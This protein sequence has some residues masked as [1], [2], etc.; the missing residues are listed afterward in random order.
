MSTGETSARLV[1]GSERGHPSRVPHGSLCPVRKYGLP[2]VALKLRV[3]PAGFKYLV[4]EMVCWASGGPEKYTGRSMADSHAHL[5]ITAKEWDAFVDDCQKTLDKFGVPA[6][7]QAEL[8]AIVSS[9]RSDI[10]V[11]G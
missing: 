2:V 11:G 10:V 1:P 5:K 3:P 9:T 4:T 8:V 7:E 6:Q